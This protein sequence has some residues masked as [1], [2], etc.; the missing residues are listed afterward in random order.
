MTQ[1]ALA[2][3]LGVTQ[4]TV[5][6]LENGRLPGTELLDGLCDVLG[7]PPDFFSDRQHLYELP[8]VF[9]RKPKRLPAPDTRA[10]RAQIN[11]LRIQIQRLLDAAD[12]PE[13]RVPRVDLG[14]PFS[15][16][17][18]ARELRSQWGVPRGPIENLTE[19]LERAGIIVVKT[20][21][22]ARADGIS[23]YPVDSTLPPMVFVNSA[24]P[25]DRARFTMAHELAH[26]VFHHHQ[27][28]P[29]AE[30]ESEADVFAAEFLMPATDIR[31]FLGNLDMHDL[32]ALKKHWRVSMQAVLKRAEDVERIKPFRAKRLWIEISRRG[33]RKHEPV[34]LPVETPTLVRKMVRLHLDELGY[35]EGELASTLRTTTNAL[36]TLLLGERHQ[37]HVVK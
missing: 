23:I 35:D 4:G 36:R 32:V 29:D 30:C 37:L 20:E 14:G 8:V 26:L 31:P 27:L 34:E 19:L 21:F 2:S 17:Q 18:V 3:S 22:P 12:L 1:T 15:P 33:Y 25:P 13:P 16:Q 7:F 5:S 10:L 11:I 6:K 28:V 9:Y 24:I